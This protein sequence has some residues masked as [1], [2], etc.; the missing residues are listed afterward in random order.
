MVISVYFRVLIIVE[1][2]LINRLVVTYLMHIIRLV[3]MLELMLA[4]PMGRL[5]QARFASCLLP[6]ASCLLPLAFSYHAQLNNV[7]NSV[8]L[9]NHYM[10][11]LLLCS[12]NI[13]WV[14]VWALMLEIISGFQDTF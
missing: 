14:L 13:R 12:G 10:N 11:L 8:T 9:F 6:L 1:L 3:Y 7:A 2:A 4:A 5:C